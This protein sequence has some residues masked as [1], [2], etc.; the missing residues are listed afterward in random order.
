[1]LF[2]IEL[3]TIYLGLICLI[4]LIYAL[5]L[6]ITLIKNRKKIN[7]LTPISHADGRLSKSAIL[8]FMLTIVVIYQ[9]A[10]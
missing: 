6:F 8:F 4:L 9:P 5:I 1:M 3:K 7:F 2:G 10:P